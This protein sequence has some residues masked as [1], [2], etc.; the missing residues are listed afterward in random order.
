[1]MTYFKEFELNTK[2]FTD[3]K[4]ITGNV[5][6]I[7]K[8]SGIKEGI[9]T[10]SIPGSTAS[11]T[12]IEYEPGLLKDLPGILE[13]IA[14]QNQEYF[15]N[16]TWHDGNGFAHIRASI[17]GPSISVPIHNGSLVLGTWQQIVVVDFDNRSRR[18]NIAVQ[19][20]GE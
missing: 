5:K 2:G 7:L 3:I 6:D 14:P 1:M 4:D 18:R 19:I 8:A 17:I 9:T 20:V 11:I 13:K 16:E 10:I 12:T 15:H